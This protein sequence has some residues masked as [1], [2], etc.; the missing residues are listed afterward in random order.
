MKFLIALSA[1]VWLYN[2]YSHFYKRHESNVM[3]AFIGRENVRMFEHEFQYYGHD[4]WA[5]GH[6]KRKSSRVHFVYSD[7][8]FDVFIEHNY[9]HLLLIHKIIHVPAMFDSDL[10]VEYLH[11]NQT[12]ATLWPRISELPQSQTYIEQYLREHNIEKIHI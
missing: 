6:L 11:R 4:L 7:S 9:K 3:L 12:V 10:V 8:P 5:F 1:V 2:M